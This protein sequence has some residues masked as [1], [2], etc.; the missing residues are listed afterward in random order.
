MVGG[1]KATVTRGRK[2]TSATEG[3]LEAV[4]RVLAEIQATLAR[5]EAHSAVIQPPVVQPPVV[6]P[7]VTAE[8]Q[9]VEQPSVVLQV[10]LTVPEQCLRFAGRF[11]LV[12]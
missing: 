12:N 11:Q 7:V 6:Q 8:V 5:I 9:S 1:G 4:F 2:A 10:Q 3:P